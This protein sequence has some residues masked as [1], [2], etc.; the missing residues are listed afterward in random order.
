MNDFTRRVFDEE[1][2]RLRLLRIGIFDIETTGLEAYFDEMICGCIV[3]PNG[4]MRTFRIGQDNDKELVKAYINAL[5]EYDLLVGWYS[6]GFDFR[7][8]NTRALIHNLKPPERNFRRDLCFV[9]RGNLQLRNNKLATVNQSL[10]G[11]SSKTYIYPKA[12]HAAIRR[13]K[14]AID[15]YVNH[16]RRDVWDTL[17]TYRKF[18]PL[19]GKLKRQ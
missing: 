16:C 2:G 7:F 10:F 11:N 17:R 3:E 13:E 14:W 19:L 5:N 1:T 12:R 4:T 15:F 6:S 18:T 8:L 9:S